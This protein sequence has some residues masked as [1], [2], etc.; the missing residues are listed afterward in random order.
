MVV[1]CYVTEALV[2]MVASLSDRKF[3]DYAIEAAISKVFASEALW[4]SADEALQI[5]G[6]NGYMCEF[7]YERLIRDSRINRIFEGTNDILRLFIA[8]SAMEDVGA[9]LK[10]IAA[11]VQGVLSDPIKGFGVLRDYAMRRAQLATGLSREKGAF[12]LI[13]PAL[14]APAAIFEQATQQLA[15]AADR[16]LR[17]HGK[18]IIEKQFA[19][20]R[21]ADIM[22]DMFALACT[23][24]RVDSSVRE[25]GAAAAHHEISILEV[26]AHEA[27]AR[28][29]ANF[30]AIDDNRDELV[31]ELADHAFQEER[32]SWDSL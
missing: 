4:R 6:G 1:D 14:K 16:I 22:I 18:H 9:E 30:N 2:S 20:R 15:V 27:K 19:S 8:L 10:E 24:S 32:F 23:L 31:K 21:L 25:K 12:K 28:I 29:Q 7:P 13:D 3:E 17:K 5:A 11:S 26:F